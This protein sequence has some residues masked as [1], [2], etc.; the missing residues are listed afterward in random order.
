ML[1]KLYLYAGLIAAAGLVYWRYDYVMSENKRLGDALA[2]EQL[3]HKQTV[4]VLS[5]ERQN[6]A[7]AAL[8]AQQFYQDVEKD[9]VELEKLRACYADKSCWPRVRIKTSC[10]AVSNSGSDTGASEEVTAE[11]GADAGQN[12]LLLRSQIKEITT[13]Y[14]ALQRE[15]IARSDPGYCQP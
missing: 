11:L 3:A 14:L 2:N 6:A 9:N 8:R 13:G 7:E 5:K 15:L 4:A 12:L 10:P 1:N